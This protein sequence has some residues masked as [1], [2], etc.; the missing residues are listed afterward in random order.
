MAWGPR[1]KLKSPISDPFH[2]VTGSS[3][4]SSR[5]TSPYPR[6]KETGNTWKQAPADLLLTLLAATVSPSGALKTDDIY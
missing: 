3:H 1:F 2:E 4:P 5:R 6:H